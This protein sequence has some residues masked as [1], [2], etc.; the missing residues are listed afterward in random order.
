M[1]EI[2]FPFD[3]SGVSKTSFCRRPS[4]VRTMVDTVAVFAKKRGINAGVGWISRCYFAIDTIDE[5]FSY[6]ASTTNKF[7]RFRIIQ[8]GPKKVSHYRKSSLN[9]IK[10]R[11]PG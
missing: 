2:I 4:L 3:G 8:G 11:Q 9:R 6:S 1:F 10:N 7:S 5:K